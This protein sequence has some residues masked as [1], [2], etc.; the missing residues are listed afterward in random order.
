MFIP[1]DSD[2][3]LSKAASLGAD[4][5]ILDLEDSVVEARKATARHMVCDYLK[6]SARSPSQLWVRINPLTTPHALRDL[7]GVIQGRPD[8][9]FLPKAE[10]AR[11]CDLLSNYLDAL[12]VEHGIDRGSTRILALVTETP[13]AML[14]MSSYTAAVNPRLVALSWGAEDLSSAV[15]AS[16]NLDAHGRLNPPYVLARSFC[17]MAAH[18]A[19]VQAVDTAFLDIQD[20]AGLRASCHE[21]RRDGF[22]GKI[23]IH[24]AQVAAINEAFMPSRAEIEHARKV[25]D[26]FAANP[27][28]GTLTLDGKMLDK[29]HVTQAERVLALAARFGL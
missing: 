20:D 13:A 27:D 3:K 28:A 16:S 24:P 25:L 6:S 2:K 19:K 22:L 14:N 5:L 7:A 11:D 23:A 29:P 8:G 12:E 21:A 18:A 17:L 26:L 15:G 4:A 1:G 10:H 9:L